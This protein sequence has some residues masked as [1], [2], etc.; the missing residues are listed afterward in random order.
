VPFKTLLTVTYADRG[1]GDLELASSLCQEINAHLSVFVVKLAAPPS[2]GRYGGVISPA[3]LEERQAEMNI[4]EKRTAAVSKLLSDSVISADISSDYPDTAWAAEIIGRRA[5]YADLTVIGPEV[6]ATDTLKSKVAEG[7]LFWSGKPILLVPEGAHATLRPKRAVVA[8]DASLEASRA[9]RESL[10]VLAGAGEVRIV[11]VDPI[12]GERHHGEE[13][14]A[15]V[16]TYLARHG[17]KVT[18]DRLPSSHHPIAYVIRQ[19]AVDV[20][21][22]LIVMGAYGHSRL[23]ERIFGGVTR[24]MIEEPRLPVLM[25]R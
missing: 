20:G 15:D 12:E 4:L 19:H 14:G 22:E 13:P 10:D 11:M 3:W 5:R 2:G 1:E 16:A 8:W 6:L 24:S 23:R 7:G 21:A 9:V 25:A 17:V 18:V